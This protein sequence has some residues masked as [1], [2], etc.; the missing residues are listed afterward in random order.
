MLDLYLSRL[1]LF[2]V[3]EDFDGKSYSYWLFFLVGT[4]L[5]EPILTP[6]LEIFGMQMSYLVA[7][8]YQNPSNFHA[9]E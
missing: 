7:Y 6:S 2:L 4:N 5:L 9:V 8:R 1:I 3:I